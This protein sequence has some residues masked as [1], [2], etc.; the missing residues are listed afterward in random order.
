MPVSAAHIAV[1]GKSTLE[2]YLKNPPEDQIKVGRPWIRKLR[3]MKKMFGG[4]KEHVVVQL[5]KTYDENGQWYF[6]EQEFLFNRRDTLDQAFYRWTGFRDGYTLSEDDFIRN[7]LSI[8]QDS[9]VSMTG[10]EKVQL[11]NIFE[12]QN[13]ALLLGFEKQLDAGFNRSGAYSVE[14]IKGRDLLIGLN[15]NQG[16]VGALNRATNEW[17]RPNIRPNIAAGNMV[18]EMEK[19]F[20]D[21]QVH[22]GMP[23][24]ID[25][26]RQAVETYRE[27]TKTEI[28]REVQVPMRGGQPGMDAGVGASNDGGVMTG[29][30]F[31]GIPIYW[32][33]VFEELDIVENPAAASRW[34]KRTYMINCM[35]ITEMPVRNYDEAAYTPPTV[36]NREAHFFA[37]RWKGA[38]IA[39]RLN[40][41]GLI[42]LA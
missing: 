22:G 27:Q 33:P 14:A 31:K 4:G 11:T 32:N 19:L 10:A 9:R 12:E 2:W 34:T 15:A 38:M 16:T 23:D 37:R 3:S 18:A 36:Y 29:L 28:V 35:D 5:R 20:M 42:I 8:S 25:M 21:C 40:G 39:K 24:Y 30:S 7:G 17:W 6:G 41:H 13:T 26:G 1:V